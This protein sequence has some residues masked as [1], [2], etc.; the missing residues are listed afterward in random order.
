MT[1]VAELF[2]NLG[3]KGSDKTL[4]A[5]GSMQKGLKDTASVSLEA[6]AAIVGAMYALEKL[7]A[8]SG[9]AGTDLTNFNTILGVSAQTLQ[10][11]QYAARQMGVSNQ[12]VEGTFKSLQGAMTKT[13]MGEGAPKGLARVSM[14]TGGMTAADLKK[15]AEQPQL[16][17][18]KLQEYAS[19]ETNAGL[20]REVLSSFGVGEG[21]QA[22]MRRGAF[23]PQA[24]AK[25]PTYSDREINSLDKANIAWSNLGNKIEMA[26]G[27][28][29]AAHGGQLVADISKLVDQV[30]KLASAFET[31]AEKAKFFQ[32]IGTAFKGWTMIFEGATKAVEAIQGAADDPAKSAKLKSNFADFITGDLPDMFKTIR[33]EV[34]GVPE[35]KEP[36]KKKEEGYSS[37]PG[38]TARE[39]TTQEKPSYGERIG[40]ALMNG[41]QGESLAGIAIDALK[42][43]TKVNV[44]GTADI[45]PKLRLAIPPSPT[46]VTPK[47]IAPAAPA[48]VGGATAAQNVEVNQT[49]NFNQDVNDPKKTSD[50]VKKSVRDAARMLSSQGQAN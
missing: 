15:F 10:K 3:V 46:Q 23:T 20:R 28:F 8:T 32:A 11:Y 7:F 25:A 29:N 2:V 39:Q 27:H 30:F 19:K 44:G 16:L 35:A 18:Q 43:G 48:G 42:A 36:E 13:L 24:L 49:L 4:G 31:L 40:N 12:E 50:S 1:T 34:I 38:S 33:D 14:L 6:K 22:A 45:K 26:V 37:G 5:L 47:A 9:Q 17:I 21:M 41:G